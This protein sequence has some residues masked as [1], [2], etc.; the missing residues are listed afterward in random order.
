MKTYIYIFKFLEKYS[1]LI[2]CE[3]TYYLSFLTKSKQFK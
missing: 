1:A 2:E 3:I